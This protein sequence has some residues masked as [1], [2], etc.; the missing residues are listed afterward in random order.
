ML[1]DRHDAAQK[2]FGNAVEHPTRS[3]PSKPSPI[4]TTNSCPEPR[5]ATSPTSLPP[6]PTVLNAFGKP[7]TKY[8]TASPITRYHHPCLVRVSRTHLPPSSPTRLKS[9]ASP[10]HQTAPQIL[11]IHSHRILLLSSPCSVQPQM[12]KSSRSSLSVPTSNV[13]SIQSQLGSS[14]N[15]FLFSSLPSHVLSTCH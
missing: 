12:K 15:L 11:T 5:N 2:T 14:R 8:S 1:S 6:T 9:Y 13:I 4:A 3:L 10:S 7:S